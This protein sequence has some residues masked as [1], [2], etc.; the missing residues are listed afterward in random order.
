LVRP[1]TISGDIGRICRLDDT[2]FGGRSG[3]M[4]RIRVIIDA[5]PPVASRYVQPDEKTRIDSKRHP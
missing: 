4:S 3:A 1:A 5:I 2:A